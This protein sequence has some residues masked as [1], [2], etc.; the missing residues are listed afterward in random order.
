MNIILLINMNFPAALTASR[1]ALRLLVIVNWVYGAA[2]FVLGI[3]SFAA[4]TPVM[5]ALGIPPSGETAP[6]IRG[7]QA[8]ML[9]GLVSIPLHY[10]ILRRLLDIV[11]SVRAGDLFVG[12]NASR[13]QII[14]WALL[15]IQLLSVV[16]GA[17]ASGVSTPAHP[18]RLNAGFSTSGWLAVLLLFVLTRV[19]AEGA[20]MRQDL[21]GTV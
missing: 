7:M 10:I 9:L 17:I 11:E 6:L 4:E 14:A 13:L 8:I 15:G 21:E 2:I 5:T 3:A 1:I 16:I 12:Q 19:F 20:R 18:L